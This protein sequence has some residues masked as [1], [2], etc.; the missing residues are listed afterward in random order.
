MNSLDEWFD[1]LPKE[2]QKILTEDKWMLAHA[3]WDAALTTQKD[4]SAESPAAMPSYVAV[5]LT[6]YEW[7]ET[8]KELE[9]LLRIAN[10]DNGPVERLYSKIASQLH[11]DTVKVNIAT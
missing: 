10:R 8:L 4:P 9:H 3:A 1:G 11:G 7:H 6:P 5:Q 2:E